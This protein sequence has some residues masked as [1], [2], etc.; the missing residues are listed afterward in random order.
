MVTIRTGY[1]S[2]LGLYTH[3][4]TISTLKADHRA[5]YQLQYSQGLSLECTEKG[6]ENNFSIWEWNRGY[7]F[8]RYEENE[9]LGDENIMKDTWTGGTAGNMEKM[10]Q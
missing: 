3:N 8:Y 5:L 7:G 1:P 10:K 4:P 9:N 6:D 2:G